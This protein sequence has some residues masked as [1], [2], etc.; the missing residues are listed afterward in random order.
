V[1][2]PARTDR[3]SRFRTRRAS[4][5]RKSAVPTSILV[6]EPRNHE[7]RLW[8]LLPVPGFRA[9]GSNLE[10]IRTWIRRSRPVF[11]IQPVRTRKP[12]SGEQAPGLSA[13]EL[14]LR[15]S[16]EPHPVFDSLNCMVGIHA[17]ESGKCP[18]SGANSDLHFVGNAYTGYVFSKAVFLLSTFLCILNILF[19]ND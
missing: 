15:S 4:H 19:I 2:S 13:S 7:M 14:D 18:K 17:T 5:L 8:P 6:R 1:P 12:G 10:S 3:F 11:P 9:S 16:P